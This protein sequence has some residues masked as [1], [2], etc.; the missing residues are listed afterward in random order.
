[1]SDFPPPNLESFLR[2]CAGEW[3][4]V[5]SRFDLGESGSGPKQ[6]EQV[7]EPLSQ[8]EAAAGPFSADPT[9]APGEPATQETWHASERG[10]LV[11]S[12]LEPDGEG[13]P[14]GLLVTP[15]SVEGRSS[16]AQRIRFTS[17]G[18]FQ[19]Q[20]EGGAGQGEGTWE[21]G[22]DGSLEL[23]ETGDWA[24]LRERIWFTKPNLRLRSSV[25]RRHD[26][27]PGRASFS[28]EIRRI[29][30]SAP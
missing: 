13:E 17:G 21:L 30:R 15:P 22:S 6:L 2:F 8:P 10:P 27:T 1:V 23:T 29:S 25:E 16:P 18:S 24:V 12:Y 28:S 26:G 5:R 7:I 9:T 20:G 19:R 11:V 14:G 4:T 3:L